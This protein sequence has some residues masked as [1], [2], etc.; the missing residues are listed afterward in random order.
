MHRPSGAHGY[1]EASRSQHDNKKE[2]FDKMVATNEFQTWLKMEIMRRSGD[3]A[4]I[5]A[6]VERELRNIKIEVK[7]EG[8]W[9]PVSEIE[10]TH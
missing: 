1:S 4:Q 10:L 3:K 6:Y 5:E 8:V 2:A 9:T 7:K